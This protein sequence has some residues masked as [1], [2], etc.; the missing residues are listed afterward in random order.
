[1]PPPPPGAF[2][3]P[4]A[5]FAGRAPTAGGSGRRCRPPAVDPA[6]GARRKRAGCDAVDRLTEDPGVTRT[7]ATFF[8]GR[9]PSGARPYEA[10]ERIVAPCRRRPPADA[11]ET[12]RPRHPPGT[13][14]SPSDPYLTIDGLGG[15]FVTTEAPRDGSNKGDLDLEPAQPCPAR[16]GT[17]RRAE[18]ARP[19]SPPHMEPVCH[20]FE[21]GA[22]T[23]CPS[24]SSD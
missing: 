8:H 9:I 14:R 13:A 16:A 7:P 3:E 2:A 4:A 1:M 20:R 24:S 10:F 21:T 22:G 11:R 19:A 23:R 17:S 18:D 6:D 5:R 15:R 12:R